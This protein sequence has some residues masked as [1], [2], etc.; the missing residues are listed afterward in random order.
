M[1]SS[2]GTGEVGARLLARCTS[3]IVLGLLGALALTSCHTREVGGTGGEIGA[4]V[5][6]DDFE[7]AEIGDAWTRGSGEAGTG[8][9]A[10]KDGWVTGSMLKNDPL[11]LATPLPRKVRIEF[12]A[13]ALT[14]TGD[15]KVEV[16]GDGENHASGYIL[17]FGGW[18]NTLDVIARL[19][20]HGD[21]RLTRTSQKVVPNQVYKMAV[22][23]SGS[24]IKW[25]VDGELFMTYP[26]DEPLVGPSNAQFAFSNWLAGVAFDN[27]KVYRLRS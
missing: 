5:F 25:F 17:I 21:D 3:P 16:F 7:R 26:D 4:L 20:E 18:N 10:I 6:S 19:D 27:V 22:E 12:D 23:R 24:A 11:W 1:R 13:K 14:A 2:R 8:Q 15:L 9:W